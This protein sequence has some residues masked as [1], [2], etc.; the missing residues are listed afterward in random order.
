MRTVTVLF[1]DLVGSTALS[2]RLDPATDDRLRDAHF[3]QLRAAVDAVGGTVVKNLGDGLMVIFDSARAALS[4]AVR[5]QQAVERH[6]RSGEPLAVRI[7][8]ATGEATES[9][10][11]YFG[12]P[13]VT[14]ARLCA[15]AD[16]GQILATEVVRVVAGRHPGVDSVDA[17]A[18]T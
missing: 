3:T 7:G 10:G 13:V 11:D 6:N 18:L 5:M 15:L 12:D 14:A 16:G 2:A 1:T 8:L 9:D 17:G 4:G